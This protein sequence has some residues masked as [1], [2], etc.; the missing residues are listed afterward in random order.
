MTASNDESDVNE[1]SSNAMT[2]SDAPASEAGE[3]QP[4]RE[5]KTSL[6]EFTYG[7]L[8]DATKHQDDKIGRLLTV[9][10]FL[11]AGALAL[12]NL[13]GG[14]KIAADFFVNPFHIPIGILCLTAFLLAIFVTVVLLITSLATPLRMPGRE[15]SK[16][17]KP[18]DEMEWAGNIET[19]QIYFSEIAKVSVSDWEKKWNASREELEKERFGMFVRE[20]HNLSV[21]TSFKYDRTTEAIAV[22]SMSL[23][24]FALAVIF[25][26]LATISESA[27]TI[28]DPINLGDPGRWLVASVLGLY[29]FIHLLGRVRYQYQAID[30]TVPGSNDVG[31]AVRVLGDRMF[32]FLFP[33]TIVCIV[34][35]EQP[36]QDDALRPFGISVLM[37]GI[38]AALIMR[39]WKDPKREKDD[40][41]IVALNWLLVILA[42]SSILAGALVGLLGHRYGF[43]LATG[44]LA[45]SVLTLLSAT[46]PA[47]LLYRSRKKFKESRLFG[48]QHAS[49]DVDQGQPGT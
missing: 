39:T 20:T 40:K 9:I 49:I 47:I 21:R 41:K 16:N 17:R 3:K 15:P 12:A 46:K 13:A 27:G 42:L 30:E 18:E 11:T 14:G 23:L 25:G 19:S 4:D 31:L 32:T 5:F 2:P 36:T 10:A 33:L 45:V 37:L 8:I 1:Q 35:V 44:I 24:A 43:Q 6:L 26:Y 7:E 22:F 48:D 34:G 28:K 29:I 38:L